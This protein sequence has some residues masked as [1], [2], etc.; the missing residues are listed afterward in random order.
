M[1]TLVLINDGPY[2]TERPYNALRLVNSLS[3]EEGEQVKLFL[4]G[5]GAVCAQRGQKTPEGYYNVERMLKVAARQNVEIGV[6]GSCMDA[7]GMAD[8]QLAEGLR[9]S[10]MQEL[11]SWTRWADKLAVF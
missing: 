2:G 5:D 3:K 9:R 1:K 6:C 4:I 10:S 8:G 11:T 7:R